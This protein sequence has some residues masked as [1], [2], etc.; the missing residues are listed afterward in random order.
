MR[1]LRDQVTAGVPPKEGEE[2]A[3]G[4]LML[5]TTCDRSRRRNVDW[6]RRSGLDILGKICRAEFVTPG[7]GPQEQDTVSPED[8]ALTNPGGS[9][10]R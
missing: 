2:T 3:T 1:V 7:G 8:P 4:T 5:T 9:G 6:T 10:G